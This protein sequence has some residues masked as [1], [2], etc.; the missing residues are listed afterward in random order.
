MKNSTRIWTRPFAAVGVLVVAGVMAA[1]GFADSEERPAGGFLYSEYLAGGSA[2]SAGS[3]AVETS[4]PFAG[5]RA[6]AGRVIQREA[7][8]ASAREV[9][10]YLIKDADLG[11]RWSERLEKTGWE[12]ADIAV[13]EAFLAATEDAKASG[14]VRTA[15]LDWKTELGGRGANVGVNFLGALRETDADAV[16]W[17]LRAYKGR[18]DRGGGNAGLLYR[19]AVGEVMAGGNV[20]LDW[21]THDVEDFWRWSLGG[22]VRSAWIDL[23]GNY[24]SGITD[25][26]AKR[27]P[28]AN[29][30][31]F[32]TEF[33]YTADGYD[34]EANVH[35]PDI[36]WFTAVAAYYNFEGQHGDDDDS[37]F[38]Y[39]VKLRPPQ[40]ALELEVYRDSG[41]EGNSFGGELSWTHRFGRAH[42]AGRAAGGFDAREYFFVAAEREY[43]Q[44]IRTY[45]DPTVVDIVIGADVEATFDGPGSI[46]A[47]LGNGAVTTYTATDSPVDLSGVTEDNALNLRTDLNGGRVTLEVSYTTTPPSTATIVVG[48]SVSFDGASL[49]L[50]YGNVSAELSDN[51][52]LVIIAPDAAMIMAEAGSEVS[53]GFGSDDNRPT[54]A[55]TLSI[56]L[57]AGE[58]AMELANSVTLLV[59]TAGTELAVMEDSGSGGLMV[60]LESGKAVVLADMEGDGTDGVDA[61]T[62]AEIVAGEESAIY[63][64][65]PG[66]Q[67]GL[68]PGLTFTP[69]ADAFAA[70]NVTVSVSVDEDG[71]R[72]RGTFFRFNIVYDSDGAAPVFPDA[73][74]DGYL[75]AG[76][77]SHT[78]SDVIFSKNPNGHPNRLSIDVFPDGRLSVLIS[79]LTPD[80]IVGLQR[81]EVIIS[82]DEL[83]TYVGVDLSYYGISDDSCLAKYEEPAGTYNGVSLADGTLYEIFAA[84][85]FSADDWWLDTTGEWAQADTNAEERNNVRE[86]TWTSI[87][88]N[89]P[90]RRDLGQGL[91]GPAGVNRVL[92][93][94]VITFSSTDPNFASD[95]DSVQRYVVYHEGGL[96]RFY[97]DFPAGSRRLAV[98]TDATGTENCYL[99]GQEF[100]LLAGGRWMTT[101]SSHSRKPTLHVDRISQSYFTGRFESRDRFV[102]RLPP[103]ENARGGL[104]R[105]FRFFE[106]QEREDVSISLVAA[107]S[108]VELAADQPET[109]DRYWLLQYASSAAADI[110]QSDVTLT[111]AYFLSDEGAPFSEDTVDATITIEIVIEEPEAPPVLTVSLAADDVTGG[112]ELSAGTVRVGGGMSNRPESPFSAPYERDNDTYPHTYTTETESAGNVLRARKVE[113]ANSI[114]YYF[115]SAPLTSGSYTVEVR[116]DE[117]QAALDADGVTDISPDVILT[118]VVEVVV[119]PA[120]ANAMLGTL[121]LAVHSNWSEMST[122]DLDVLHFNDGNRFYAEVGDTPALEV[123]QFGHLY[124]SHP[125]GGELQAGEQHT[126]VLS[127]SAGSGTDGGGPTY[128]L[129][130]V[131]TEAPDASAATCPVVYTRAS[132]TFSGNFGLNNIE[133]DLSRNMRDL[134]VALR[135]ADGNE[136]PEDDWYRWNLYR[137]RM[138]EVVQGGAHEEGDF[139]SPQFIS[140]S[141]GDHE[142]FDDNGNLVIGFEIFLPQFAR[143]PDSILGLGD[144]VALEERDGP[145]GATPTGRHNRDN[146]DLDHDHIYRVYRDGTDGVIRASAWYLAEG[147]QTSERTHRCS[148]IDNDEFWITDDGVRTE[149]LAA[150]GRFHPN[151]PD[152]NRR[153][154]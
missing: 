77:F 15:E 61:D 131:E 6:K 100:H 67:W 14:F 59:T 1:S 26:V 119:P 114:E 25:S 5:F 99:D 88:G 64:F 28:G 23:F 55:T 136:I 12:I 58:A 52:E 40:A 57:N 37:G 60:S 111:A 50:A 83:F 93:G 13:H 36:Q 51:N 62:V 134:L 145:F 92:S 149:N 17:Q 44:R 65:P 81:A 84:D 90:D 106:T 70:S 138:G 104:V 80:G 96:R 153:R 73:D 129:L 142:L 117:D 121:T 102:Y 127:V 66:R 144:V 34:V 24:Y 130:I 22:E 101:T 152:I 38:R 49:T 69:N 89:D 139:L 125:D 11:A 71:S 115:A 133:V 112:G 18:S 98:Q 154:P 118:Q 110:L 151:P 39:G 31:E 75:L 135:V 123:N 132:T 122:V 103:N 20:F 54:A 76:T 29:T 150:A 116:V 68:I 86:P 47:V 79:D 45:R 137:E 148:L 107:E 48:S 126:L 146:L 128:R 30:G 27:V 19:R 113:G 120:A 109:L 143:F 42:T 46:F 85:G 32:R 87:D 72:T 82:N 2:G 4:R 41:D 78:D 74:G 35:S 16:A 33:T 105:L 21:E 141:L 124:M 63:T 95:P 56:G 43:T 108:D 53:V 140:E 94:D 147:D 9:L 91:A 8:R 3:F 10:D 7:E 97:T